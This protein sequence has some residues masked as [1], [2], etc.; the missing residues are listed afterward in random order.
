M[1]HIVFLSALIL[2]ACSK[3]HNTTPTIPDAPPAVTPIGSP[4][5]TGVTKSIGTSGGS[6]TSADGRIELTIPANALTATTAIGIQAITNT[7]PGGRG[8]AY[9]LTPDGTKFSTPV[10]LTFHYTD[11]D[12]N[13]TMP[14]LFYVAYQDNTGKWYA[15][16]RNRNVDS[17]A[18]TITESIHHFSI[19][20]IG[21]EL[22]ISTYPALL[23]ESQASACTIF[24]TKESSKLI[25]DPE[26]GDDLAT[27]PV[28]EPIAGNAVANWKVNG[29]AGGNAQD[30]TIAGS[31]SA[32]TY[33]APSTIDKERTVQVSAEVNYEMSTFNNGKLS[34]SLNKFLLFSDITLEPAKMSF[35]I[36]AITTLHQTSETYNDTYT[37]EVKFQIDI[38][39]GNITASNIQNFAPNVTPAS[40]SSGNASATWVPDGIG[41]SNMTGIGTAILAPDN[42]VNI[43]LLH[44]G[45]ILPKWT[46]TDQSG[47]YNTGGTSSPGTPPGIVFIAKDSAQTYDKV[48]GVYIYTVTP[49]H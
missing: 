3:S 10:T 20:T 37:D 46:I 7:A 15:D 48:S 22:I 1:R 24:L 18:H 27:L 42:S 31:G 45:T 25:P 9:H 2:V 49:L 38:D 40:G 12:I 8:T 41:I 5:D 13:G 30:G 14:Y 39:H 21:S 33:T 11:A 47:T 36:D 19:W 32:A 28:S 29:A 34:A 16:F 6:V 26:G 35:E 43:L 17:V 23:N 44:S 4:V